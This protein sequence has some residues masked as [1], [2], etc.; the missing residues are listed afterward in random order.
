MTNCLGHVVTYEYDAGLA[1][2]TSERDP[3]NQLTSWR[4][5]VLGR[6]TKVIGPLD[7]ET[8]PSVSYDYADFGTP[9]L[10]R[11]ITHRREEHGQAGTIWSEEYFDGLN[12]VDQTR[13]EGPNGDDIVTETVFD[14]RGQVQK[15]SAPRFS[16]EAPIW[17]EHEYD[18]LGR[19][20]QVKVGGV[21]RE[22]RIYGQH[23]VR[24][25]NGNLKEKREYTDAY[26]R[27]LK[28]E[29]YN[30]S[31]PY[32][33][34]YFYDA[35]D[36]LVRVINA[37]GHNTTMVY[38]YLGRKV[39]M[40]DPNMGASPTVTV[41]DPGPPNPTPG[42][43]R[44]TYS[45]AG[46][47]LTQIDAKG[48]QLD[49]TY[50]SLGRVLT[51]KQG[52]TTIATWT[53]DDP[54]V[55]FSKGRLTKVVDRPSTLNFQTTFTFDAMGRATQTGRSFLNTSYT[56]TLTQSY[57]ALN[58]IKS[59]TFSDEPGAPIQ[60]TYN[61]AG[62]LNAVPG[63]ITS[64]SYNAR[65]QK[66]QMNYANGISTTWS[67][68]DQPADTLKNLAVKQRLTGPGNSYQN[69]TYT[70]DPVG[71]V[72]SVNDANFSGLKSFGYDDLNR[73]VSS[74]G[75]GYDYDA[76][77][78]MINNCWYTQQY[79][80]ASHP[81]AITHVPAQGK[82]FTYDL[83]GNMNSRN[84]VA[85][86][87]DIDNRVT[88]I[89]S[90]SMEYDYTGM[91]VRK[92]AGSTMHYPFKGY[93]VNLSTGTVTKFIRIGQEIYASRIGAT[94]FFYHNDHLGGVNV[95]TD[96][97]GNI[98]QRTEY[99]TW[100]GITYSAGNVDPTHRFTGQEL[101]PESGLMYYGGRYYDNEVGRF[102]SPDPYVQ[103]PDTPQNLNRYTYV[104][105]NPQ[106]YVDPSG[107]FWW[108][109]AGLLAASLP[110][111]G[112]GAAAAGLSAAA[113]KLIAFSAIYAFTQSFWQTVGSQQPVNQV[114][115][116]PPPKH[117][118]A[119]RLPGTTKDD[120][121]GVGSD[122]DGKSWW[123]RMLESL[124]PNAEAAPGDDGETPRGGPISGYPGAM[125]KKPGP[126]GPKPVK[127]IEDRPPTPGQRKHWEKILQKDGKRAL[128][129]ALKTAQQTLEEHYRKL[130]KI[131]QE[132]GFTAPVERTIQRMNHDIA[133][134]RDLL[135]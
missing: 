61:Q 73:V 4:Y 60:Y 25:F 93:D 108:A 76:I 135:K 41:C 58:R 8:Y 90:A 43:W 91:R 99:N 46:D 34:N 113:A 65:G 12:R 54:T 75:C 85:I 21:V 72:L 110:E 26:N 27:L 128:E 42:A 117:A 11:T 44:Y 124:I 19:Q 14:T 31:T 78:N 103:E 133:I 115:L 125:V 126:S 88:S 62:W 77:G 81:S 95:I 7:S 33:T 56:Y 1:K 71:N 68:Y 50:D 129:K 32:T 3:N 80:D 114:N 51:K 47:M 20:T 120:G 6:N 86:G 10:Q 16:S 2:K 59:E 106:S 96:S 5:D 97:A 64:I 57:D 37:V 89:G 122:G 69:F 9:S 39:L 38:D 63:Y 23:M 15:K 131:N 74:N 67:Y 127:T 17:T 101:D 22:Q 24:I 105:N 40:C 18:V 30:S 87:W 123:E 13:S 92:T 130:A 53:Y 134:M 52:S 28:V 66:S 107:H 82:V 100:G 84:G 102:I 119:T 121:G 55:L 118:D 49:F 79:N 104:M 111:V 132:G 83:N 70:Y 109:L 29:E 94:K 98:S 48:Q 36:S 112:A 35:A 116:G 45:L